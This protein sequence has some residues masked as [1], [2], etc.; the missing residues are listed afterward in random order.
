MTTRPRIKIRIRPDSQSVNGFSE[1]DSLLYDS[2]SR[3]NDLR[4]PERMHY[5]RT[6][7]IPTLH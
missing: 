3:A 4:P 7:H 5:E 1:A 6:A 2:P